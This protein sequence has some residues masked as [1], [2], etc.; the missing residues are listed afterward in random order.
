MCPR[1]AFP[2]GLAN[3]SEQ[4][5]SAARGVEIADHSQLRHPLRSQGPGVFGGTR[6][7]S[8]K[9]VRGELLDERFTDNG[10]GLDDEDHRGCRVVAGEDAVSR[11]PWWSA[12]RLT[13][14]AHGRRMSIQSPDA[15][16]RNP[17]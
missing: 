11:R 13:I 15:R 4:L 2:T 17:L 5:Q 12:H 16:S 9:A 8:S 1:G 7:L 14:G 6:Q 3:L 10:I